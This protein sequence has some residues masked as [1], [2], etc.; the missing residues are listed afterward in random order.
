MVNGV[1]LNLFYYLIIQTKSRY[2][3][4][5]ITSKPYELK[6]YIVDPDLLNF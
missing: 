1:S 4:G 2:D 3:N 6:V 5:N